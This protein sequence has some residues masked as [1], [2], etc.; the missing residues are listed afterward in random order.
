MSWSCDNVNLFS[1]DLLYNIYWCSFPFARNTKNPK[2]LVRRS[3]QTAMSVWTDT[4]LI[5][6]KCFV[7]RARTT[8][9]TMR[10]KS[11][12]SKIPLSSLKD[13]SNT[14]SRNPTDTL[15]KPWMW[16][17]NWSWLRSF[18]RKSTFWRS[19]FKKRPWNWSTALSL[20]STSTICARKGSRIWQ[21]SS[22]ISKNLRRINSFLKIVSNSWAIWIII[23]RRIRWST[24]M[25]WPKRRRTRGERHCKTPRGRSRRFGTTPWKL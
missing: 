2:K 1:V 13:W 19:R 18:E 10:S 14:P 15:G 24:E 20:W 12:Q 8:I 21:A 9:E 4:V 5:H 25:L 17:K 7:Q 11:S 23:S 16:W 3:T 22:Q 6:S